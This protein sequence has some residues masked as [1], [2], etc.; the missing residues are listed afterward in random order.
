MVEEFSEAAPDLVVASRYL[1]GRA[2]G[3]KGLR[4][5][6]SRAGVNLSSLILG[7]RLADP[8]SGC[9][10]MRRAWYEAARPRLSGLGFK[11]LAD[12]AVSGPRR[13][14]VAQ[15]PT[16]LRPRA[17][18]ESKLDMRVIFDLA[19]MLVEKHTGGVL[20]A[21]AFQ[22]LAVGATGV[23]VHLG[24]LGL[25][26]LAETP[27]WA[28]QTLA[29][30]AAMTWNFLL[31]N[32]LTFRDQRL[33]GANLW[34]GLLSFYA[35]CLGGALVSDLAGAGLHALDAPWAL[36]GVAG[37][38]LGAAWNYQ[39]AKRVTWRTP[40]APDAAPSMPMAEAVTPSEAS[41]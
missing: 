10:A 8:M 25:T 12:V 34:R 16:A 13:P 9:F 30:W 35:A 15:I 32:G 29:I 40:A 27:F 3:L 20:S 26:Q 1:D 41:A 4:H 17:G 6:I 24:V 5:W 22:F 2:S 38:V 36:A 23:A 18:G 19:A 11:I 37:A 33:R 7:L 21:R 28:G 39:A 14:T 31:N